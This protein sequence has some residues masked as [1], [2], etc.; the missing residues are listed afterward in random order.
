HNKLIEVDEVAA[1]AMWIC[2]PGSQSINGQTIEI[3]GG[4]V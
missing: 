3:A 1:A 2:G 4:Q